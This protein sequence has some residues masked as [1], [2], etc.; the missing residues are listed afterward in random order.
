MG[1][2]RK[3]ERRIAAA[4]R[5][6]ERIPRAAP[7][8]GEPGAD[9]YPRYRAIVTTAITAASG[10]SPGQGAAK[11][12]YLDTT[13]PLYRLVPGSDTAPAKVYSWVTSAVTAGTVIYVRWTGAAYEIAG[14]NC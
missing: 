1:F 10:D 12:Y 13:T 7:L 6:V 2:S 3:A 4:V 9:P 5:A 8:P 11:L 14:T